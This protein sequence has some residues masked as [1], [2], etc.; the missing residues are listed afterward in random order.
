VSS[1]NRMSRAKEA[2]IARKQYLPLAHFLALR[3]PLD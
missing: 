3:T 2:D 1:M